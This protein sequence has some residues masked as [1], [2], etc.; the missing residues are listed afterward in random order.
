[1]PAGQVP[2]SPE[3]PCSDCGRY[4]LL[5]GGT[6]QLPVHI[7]GADMTA[8]LVRQVNNGTAV[9]WSVGWIDY[10]DDSH[11]ADMFPFCAQTLPD[12]DGL[13]NWQRC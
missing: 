5:P 4:F 12:A 6:V 10:S 9:L 3:R 2:E 8:A 1:M 7:D 13:F 11:D